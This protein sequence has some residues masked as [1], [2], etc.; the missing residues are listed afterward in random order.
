[1]EG[2]GGGRKGGGRGSG[3]EAWWWWRVSGRVH[4]REWRVSVD[5]EQP[6]LM[7]LMLLLR[8]EEVRGCC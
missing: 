2:G 4:V 3:S 6:M 1:M 8:N 5:L 7:M